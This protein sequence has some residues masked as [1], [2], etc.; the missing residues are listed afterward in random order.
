MSWTRRWTPA[1]TGA[2]A[3]LGLSAG[4][5]LLALWQALMTAP[6]PDVPIA[7]PRSTLPVPAPAPATSASMRLAALQANPFRPG[8][9]P[10]P[11]GFRMP[12]DPTVAGPG[13]RATDALVLIGTVVLP[14]DR[15]FALCR[16]VT[17]APRMVRLG[18]RVGDFTLKAVAQGRATFVSVAGAS[19]DLRVAKGGPIN[20]N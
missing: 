2:A 16:L 5:M 17:E 20:A 11:A 3:A 4:L 15:G 14:E 18:E 6:V 12:S 13:I 9:S 1:L 19:V 7:S 10:A 8:R